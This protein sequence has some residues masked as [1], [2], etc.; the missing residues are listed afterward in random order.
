MDNIRKLEELKNVLKVLSNEKTFEFKELENLY[1]KLQIEIDELDK[2][3][4]YKM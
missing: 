3:L 1:S 2:Y 4:S